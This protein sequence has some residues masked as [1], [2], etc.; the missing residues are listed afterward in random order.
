MSMA[1]HSA[2]L[3]EVAGG[4]EAPGGY[5][6]GHPV[7][8][9]VPYV[10]LTP[11]EAVD[12]GLVEVEADHAEARLGEGEGQREAHVA[13][14]DDAHHGLAVADASRADAACCPGSEPV[15][16]ATLSP[17]VRYCRDTRQA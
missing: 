13:L 17:W 14:P 8:A 4:R 2:R 1:S 15:D 3:R 9:H 10:R 16:S 7:G 11:V 5:G 12:L 6:L